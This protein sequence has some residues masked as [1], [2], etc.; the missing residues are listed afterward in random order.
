MVEKIQGGK[1][2]KEL[3]KKGECALCLAEAKQRRIRV[4][5][6]APGRGRV[7]KVSQRRQAGNTRI[8]RP[9]WACPICQVRLCVKV[10]K[11]CQKSC[12]KRWCHDGNC[13]P[14]E[15]QLVL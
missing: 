6:I 4:E 14:C 2:G 10:R 3:L 13:A 8:P 11:G 5:K 7:H 1:N 9:S 12:F 15:R